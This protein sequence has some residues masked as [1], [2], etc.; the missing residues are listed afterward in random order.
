M[1]HMTLGRNQIFGLRKSLSRKA[2]IESHIVRIDMELFFSTLHS[3][4]LRFF[5]ATHGISL[6][7]TCSC[8][9]KFLY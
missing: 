9:P 2:F 1:L 5:H 8:F 6:P 4:K 3:S 7:L